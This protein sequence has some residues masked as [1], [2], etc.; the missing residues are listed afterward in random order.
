MK[1]EDV[2]FNW[3]QIKVVADARPD[4]R[5]AVDTFEF[6]DQI[7]RDDH[8]VSDIVF[9]KE[10]TMY[11]LHYTVDNERKMQIYDIDRIDQLLEAI[12]QEP[13]FNME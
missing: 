2:L 3:L 7:L 5:S 10:E 4:D 1:L 13:K 6:F 11:T 12:K 9:N 8:K